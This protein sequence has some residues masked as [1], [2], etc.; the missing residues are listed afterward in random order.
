MV[1]NHKD[2]ENN[3]Y[4]VPEKL[5]MEIARLKLNAMGIKIDTLTKEQKEYLNSWKSGT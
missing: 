4:A 1:K 2:L 3:V 5:D